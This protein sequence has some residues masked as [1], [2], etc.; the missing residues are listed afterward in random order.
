[1]THNINHITVIGA[2]AMGSQIAMVSALAGFSTTV[3]DIS[4]DSLDRARQQLWSRVDRDGEKGRRT[5]DDVQQAKDRLAFSTQRDE[6]VADTDFV[7][8]AAIED[9]SIKRD[10]FTQLDKTAPA[11]AILTTNSSNIMSS[12]IA[13]AT[14]RPDKVC[15]MHFF[16]PAL[17]MA[18]VEVVPHAGTSQETIETTIAVTEAF[19][20]DVIELKQEI[21][22]FVANRLLNAIRVE[23]LNLY[24]AGIADFED[25]DRAARSALRH[26]MGPF[27]LMDLVGI[28]VAYLVRMAEYE[29]TG[30]EAAKPHPKLAE[31]YEAGDY[32][33][34]TGQGWYQYAE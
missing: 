7:I 32:G 12:Q 6:A 15:N 33:R 30:D 2:G 17:V 9:R 26:P 21:P 1:M 22:G 10:I 5:A 25:I 20:K 27:E 4:Q 29:Q 28:D 11:H 24:D 13:D 19:G 31:K 3:V 34:K 14:N 16:N 18:G 23:A 8:E